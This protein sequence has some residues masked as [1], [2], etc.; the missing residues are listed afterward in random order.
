MAR[1]KIELEVAAKERAS[2]ERLAGKQAATGQ[3]VTEAV[4]RVERAQLQ[5]QQLAPKRASLVDRADRTVAQAK[6]HEAQ[7]ATELARRRL[8][9][10]QIRAPMAGIVYE[11]A[12]GPART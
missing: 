3:E 7:T 10:A 12:S 4:R 6:L 2:L 1:A 9:K 8:E 5:L 11:T